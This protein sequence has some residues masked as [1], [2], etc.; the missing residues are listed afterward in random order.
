MA[1]NISSSIF[2]IMFVP[3][4]VYYKIHKRSPLETAAKPSV[5]MDL[6]KMVAVVVPSPAC[7]FVLLATSWRV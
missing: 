2:N 3:F 1:I 4:L 6:A 7:S 5:A